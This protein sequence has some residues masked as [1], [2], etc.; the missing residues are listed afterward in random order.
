[1]PII[2]NIEVARAFAKMNKA[3]RDYVLRMAGDLGGSRRG[4]RKGGRR[5]AS[6]PARKSA[7]VVPKASKKKAKKKAGKASEGLIGT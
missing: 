4:R 1:M 3:D 5:K 6:A 7:A 2:G